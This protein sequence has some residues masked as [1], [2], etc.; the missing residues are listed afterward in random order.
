ML[1]GVHRQP[2]PGLD[3]QPTAD[4]VGLFQWN[5]KPP[6]YWWSTIRRLFNGWQ[7]TKATK[8]DGYYTARYATA[9]RTDPHNAARVAA[10]V[11][12]THPRVWPITWHCKGIYDGRRGRIR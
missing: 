11:I 9:D 7:D 8:S 4:D 1:G 3:G 6:R 5:E 12:A 10:W 2:P